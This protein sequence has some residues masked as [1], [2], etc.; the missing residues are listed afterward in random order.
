MIQLY[1]WLLS[2]G[3]EAYGTESVDEADAAGQEPEVTVITYR[4]RER[5]AYLIEVYR[6]SDG[7]LM[8]YIGVGYEGEML[9][10]AA[11]PAEGMALDIWLAGEGGMEV[12][13]GQE[14]A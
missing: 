14:Q 8:G 2:L 1:S 13:G 6:D 9:S 5:D 7:C 4:L 3:R 10:V 11:K 12:D